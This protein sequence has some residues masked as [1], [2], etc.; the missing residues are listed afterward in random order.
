MDTSLT[1]D[2][3]AG[4][5][6]RY[7]TNL[8]PAI[9]YD[10]RLRGRN[11]TRFLLEKLVNWSR[12]DGYCKATDDR[13][14]AEFQCSVRTIQNWLAKLEECGH[15]ERKVTMLVGLRKKVRRIFVSP[16]LM[17]EY[18]MDIER[19]PNYQFH[20]VVIGPK[21][22]RRAHYI[23][24]MKEASR[25]YRKE[26]RKNRIKTPSYHKKRKAEKPRNNKTSAV[27]F[28]GGIAENCTTSGMDLKSILPNPFPSESGDGVTA[29]AVSFFDR[30]RDQVVAVKV[31]N[32]E[33]LE[34]VVGTLL[35]EFGEEVQLVA[36]PGDN[37]DTVLRKDYA[38]EL[39]AKLGLSRL[40]EK[41]CCPEAPAMACDAIPAARAF[42]D[43]IFG[44]NH[45]SD[46]AFFRQVGRLAQSGKLG[47]RPEILTY[48]TTFLSRSKMASRWE[49]RLKI[50]DDYTKFLS[51]PNSKHLIAD[52]AADLFH[53]MRR[54]VL[55]SK[56]T[57]EIREATETQ[58]KSYLG[59]ANSLLNVG[60]WDII[61]ESALREN[62]GDLRSR[63]LRVCYVNWLAR[64]YCSP[65]EIEV[66]EQA[67]AV[68]YSGED[69]LDA[70]LNDMGLR[71][72]LLDPAEAPNMEWL[73]GGTDMH[74]IAT[75]AL[76]ERMNEL[77]ADLP[78]AEAKL[79][80][81]FSL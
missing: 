10:D 29:S 13:L 14:A 63:T 46:P 23:K 80:T 17:K 31:R 33:T 37:G 39:I 40:A 32:P 68:H 19:Y 1:K 77:Y 47:D 73:T 79:K 76:L 44:K 58:L 18:G 66:L 49:R 12:A 53:D 75:Q 25:Q 70:F 74:D 67:T 64:K 61:T 36:S 50:L 7:G 30:S 55:P 2:L 41:E 38:L 4:S 27:V 59:H 65:E 72:I 28:K 62:S 5:R 56:E 11:L 71:R 60:T 78:L 34:D 22:D 42:L 8:Q 43:E 20:E 3:I 35:Q 57:T 16:T 52:W 15:I 54:L 45:P 9:A 48:A 51:D 24:K 69:M 6:Y 26:C 21:V 81:E